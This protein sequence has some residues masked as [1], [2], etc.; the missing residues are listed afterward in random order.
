MSAETNVETEIETNDNGMIYGL[1]DVPKPFSKT[2]GLSI[3]AILTMFGATV[4]VPLLVGPKLGL[5]P[6]Q[7]AILVSA[8]FIAAGLAT[9]VQVNFGTRLPIIQGTS[10][11]FLAPFFAIIATVDGG[12]AE[13]MAYISGAVISGALVEAFI[14]FSGLMGVLRKYITPVV[15]GPTIMLIGLGLYEAGA[16]QAGQNWIISIIV[17][18]AVFYFSLMSKSKKLSLFPIL[19]AVVIGYIVALFMTLTGILEPGMPGY[20]DFAPVTNA[21]WFRDPRSLIFPWGMPKFKLSFFFAILAAY[22]ASAIE[23]FGDYFSMADVAGASEPTTKQINRGIGSEG[24]GCLLAGL[25]GAFA[26]TSYTENIGLVGLT[27]VASRYVTTVAAV[28]LIVLGLFAKTGA[29]VATIPGPVVG[30]VYCAL[31]GLI[32]AVGLSNLMKADMGSQRNQ[33]IV[34]FALFMGLSLPVYFGNNPLELPNAQVLAEIVNT[35]GTTGM[36]V[37]AILALILD[38]VIPGTDE[39]RGI[40]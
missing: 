10:F 37:T 36:G 9:L 40:A 35:I 17:I 19:I 27:K 16:P 13:T 8:C 2:L 30:G 34:G 14:G 11:S 33:M 21:P 20:V 12:G 39:E 4:A 26:N 1:D 28:L 25:V 24:I 3:Q 22:L 32:A 6:V 38:N 18:L 31:F 5:G 29:L 7:M 23:S 15:I